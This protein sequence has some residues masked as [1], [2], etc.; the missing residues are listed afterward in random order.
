M[1]LREAFPEMT[2]TQVPLGPFT[3]LRVG[4]AAEFL[5]QPRSADELAAVMQ[6]AN[7]NRIPA[8]V[9]GVGSNIL[10]RDEGVSGA[11]IRLSEPAFTAV[12]VNGKKIRAGGGASLAELISQSVRR[13][14]AAL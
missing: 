3:T 1:T 5:V 6:F 7:A 12:A 8:R 14:L 2:R 9:M 11:V 13:G 10:V 4:G